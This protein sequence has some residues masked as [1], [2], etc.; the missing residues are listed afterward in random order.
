[1]H[2][3]CLRIYVSF[4]CPHLKCWGLQDYIPE[5]HLVLYETWDLHGTEE[6][7]CGLLSL[8][9][10]SLLS[11]YRC[12]RGIY[13][14]HVWMDNNMNYFILTIPLKPIWL[15]SFKLLGQVCSFFLITFSITIITCLKCSYF[16]HFILELHNAQ[17]CSKLPVIQHVWGMKCAGCM[18]KTLAGT[19]HSK[20][21]N[22]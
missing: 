9:P 18:R 15:L 14:V 10:C 21:K 12:F 2:A 20:H 6:S 17:I 11:G 4:P 1:M 13:R 19:Q 7:F 22:D 5:G 16:I 8:I 3:L